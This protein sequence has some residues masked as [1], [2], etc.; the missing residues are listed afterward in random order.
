MQLDNVLRFHGVVVSGDPHGLAN[1]MANGVNLNVLK[2][3]IGTRLTDRNLVKLLAPANPGIEEIYT[4]ASGYVH[5][6]GSHIGHFLTRSKI[7]SQG[8][9]LF[10]IGDD[11]EY[12]DPNQKRHLISVFATLTRC[13]LHIVQQWA[14][15]R[16]SHG[17]SEELAARFKHAL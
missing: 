7:D 10:A 6:S 13:V 14:N 16:E 5:L 15:G 3:G 11:D 17:T 9:R 4:N 8:N 2:N 1:Q 12:M